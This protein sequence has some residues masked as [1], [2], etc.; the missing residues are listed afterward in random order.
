MNV[1]CDELVESL[2]RNEAEAREVQVKQ[3]K[4]TTQG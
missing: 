1:W 4:D 2:K 3:G